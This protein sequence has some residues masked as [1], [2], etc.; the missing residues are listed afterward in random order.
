MEQKPVGL[1]LLGRRDPEDYYSQQEIAVLQSLA[2]Q[3]AIALTNIIYADRLRALYQNDIGQREAERG[4][5]ARE[6]HDNALH[7]LLMLKRSVEEP[8][9]ALEFPAAYELL[10]ADLR[11]I[12]SDLRPAT[13]NY[14]LRPALDGLVD[15]LS[16]RDE[17]G[18]AISLEVSGAGESYGP[19]VDL[20]AY[21]IVQQAC[22]NTLEHAH[23]K[24]LTISGRL[25]PDLIELTVE[26]DGQGFDVDAQLDLA[27]LVAHKHFGLAGLYERAAIIGAE[28]QID[29]APGRGTRVTLTWRSSAK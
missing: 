1:W 5:L 24:T 2:N 6:L 9:A 17:S 3:T 22:E 23:A 27:K 13:L 4:H 16:G 11:Q 20:H 19:E 8:T 7:Q 28:L 14:G 18:P 26:D 21:R 12:I 15:A 29:S 10:V 25:E